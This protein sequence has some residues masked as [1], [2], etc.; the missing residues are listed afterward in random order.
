MIEIRAVVMNRSS[1][2]SGQQV[3]VRT[4]EK[5]F[6]DRNSDHD[7]CLCVACNLVCFAS[8]NNL[9]NI[10]TLYNNMC[11]KIIFGVQKPT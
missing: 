11:N 10:L 2:M 6:R 4:K 8:T 1:S 3:R 5:K 7:I 9:G